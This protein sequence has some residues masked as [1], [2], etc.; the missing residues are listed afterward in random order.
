MWLYQL[1]LLVFCMTFLAKRLAS[2]AKSN[3]VSVFYSHK[4]T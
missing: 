1:P 2:K 4:N 3:N